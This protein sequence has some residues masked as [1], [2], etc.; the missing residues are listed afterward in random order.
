[1]KEVSRR[2]QNREEVCSMLRYTYKKNANYFSSFVFLSSNFKS[3]LSISILC[4]RIS[5]KSGQT[6]QDLTFAKYVK[7]W[8]RGFALLILFLFH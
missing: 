4:L 5:G 1:M 8:G 6:L 7:M 3:S 2:Q